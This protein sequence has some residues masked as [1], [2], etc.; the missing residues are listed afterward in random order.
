MWRSEIIKGKQEKKKRRVGSFCFLFCLWN[1]YLFTVPVKRCTAQAKAQHIW[2]K[3]V[4]RGSW[5][6]GKAGIELVLLLQSAYNGTGLQSCRTLM[7]IPLRGAPNPL[8]NSSF[9]PAQHI[10][11][12]ADRTACREGSKP[13]TAI[14]LLKDIFL[15]CT[16]LLF[17]LLLWL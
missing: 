7:A 5:K 1:L 13:R 2:M 9:P 15:A 6:M 10:S 17:N 11:P 4:G 14:T 3:G 16:E 12:W 8:H